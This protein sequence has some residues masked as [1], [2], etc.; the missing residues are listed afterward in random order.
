MCFI[1]RTSLNG[2][3]DVTDPL[4]LNWKYPK[5]ISIYPAAASSQRQECGSDTPVRRL[6][7]WL[8]RLSF[9][10]CHAN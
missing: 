3:A 1:I 7:S 8:V 2:L 4:G 10:V 9:S 5:K 6:W